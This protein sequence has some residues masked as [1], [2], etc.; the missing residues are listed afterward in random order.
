MHISY[1]SDSQCEFCIKADG[2]CQERENQLTYLRMEEE[3]NL[4]SKPNSS[5]TVEGIEERL[6]IAG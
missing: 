2:H 5:D 4:L 3:S 6:L 1:F